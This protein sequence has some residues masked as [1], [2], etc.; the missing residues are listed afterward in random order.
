MENDNN[1][2]ENSKSG[3]AKM[4]SSQILYRVVVPALVVFAGFCRY[5]ASQHEM[6]QP[7]QIA[8]KVSMQI[9]SE[10]AAGLM[11]SL[12]AGSTGDDGKSDEEKKAAAEKAAA[13]EKRKNEVNS[14]YFIFGSVEKKYCEI[15]P[16]V[17][18]EEGCSFDLTAKSESGSTY[19]WAMYV[20]DGKPAEMWCSSEKLTE[21][22]LTPQSADVKA[23]GKKIKSKYYT[24]NNKKD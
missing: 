24:F 15:E 16:C 7:T 5:Q 20:D 9:L 1:S 17:P 14:D 13:Q 4:S 21:D 3:R 8:N 6:K 11:D 2:M 12:N 18:F 22:M 23:K 19:N 10:S